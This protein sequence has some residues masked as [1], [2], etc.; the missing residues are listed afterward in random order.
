MAKAAIRTY[1]SE[2]DG[3]RPFII[4]ETSDDEATR[5]IVALANNPNVKRVVVHW[6]DGGAAA[7]ESWEALPEGHGGIYHLTFKVP[8]T[9]VVNLDD[10]SIDR[11]V[12]RDEEVPP[13][14]DRLVLDDEFGELDSSEA[15]RRIIR[16]VNEV[17]D[18]VEWPAWEFGW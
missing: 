13:A 3:R 6:E 9:V 2:D 12:V 11:V 8:V 15:D 14:H 10:E 5:Q 4:F 18:E 1:P 17:A 7:P 16:L